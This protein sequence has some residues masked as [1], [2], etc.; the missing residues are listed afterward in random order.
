[1]YAINLE[2]SNRALTFYV[3]EEAVKDK[4]LRYLRQG[5]SVRVTT[6]NLSEPASTPV[7]FD[8]YN[9]PIFTQVT[10]IPNDLFARIYEGEST[11][12]RVEILSHIED[13][14]GGIETGSFYVNGAETPHPEPSRAGRRRSLTWRDF[15]VGS[16]DTGVPFPTQASD[17]Y[18]TATRGR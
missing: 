11:V 15:E 17:T 3:A 7:T 14:V 9:T 2:L 12:S 1:M 4:F 13:S 5:H 16:S 6:H 10:E 8:I 18:E